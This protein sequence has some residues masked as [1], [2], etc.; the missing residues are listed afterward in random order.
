MDFSPIES[1]SADLPRVQKCL[2]SQPRLFVSDRISTEPQPFEDMIVVK[3]AK[4]RTRLH[5]VHTERAS[6]EGSQ[7]TI[8]TLTS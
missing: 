8:C 6:Y 5:W 2:T 4:F 1:T 3:F 7:D